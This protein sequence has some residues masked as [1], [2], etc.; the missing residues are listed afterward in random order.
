MKTLCIGETTYTIETVTAIASC[1]LADNIRQ[2]ALLVCYV[3]DFGEDIE[4][5]VFGYEIPEDEEDFNAIADDSFAWEFDW[6]VLA[7]VQKM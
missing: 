3:N 7:T 5:V 2:D 4:S 1:D 6:E